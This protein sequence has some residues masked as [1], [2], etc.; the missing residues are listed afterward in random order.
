MSLHWPALPCQPKQQPWGG[1]TLPLQPPSLPHAHP[2]DRMKNKPNI[3]LRESHKTPK[4]LSHFI[5]EESHGDLFQSPLY[6]S[7]SSWGGGGVQSHDYSN[8]YTLTEVQAIMMHQ[9]CEQT[10]HLDWRRRREKERKRRDPHPRQ[11]DR[12]QIKS[13]SSLL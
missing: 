13:K 2:T 3:C 1:L 12:K 10:E 4:P 8:T 6:K 9:L 7:P 5:S 11:T